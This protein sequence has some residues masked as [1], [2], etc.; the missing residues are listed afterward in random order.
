MGPIDF[1]K[2]RFQK[3]CNSVALVSKGIETTYDELLEVTNRFIEEL[4]D[5]GIINGSI[6]LLRGDYSVNSICAL[7]ALIELRC[8]IV[9]LTPI[10]FSALQSSIEE[11][12]AQF[13]V[14][15]DSIPIYKIEKFQPKISTPNLFK[16]LIDRELPGLVLFTS[17]SS[18]NPKAVVHDFSKLLEKF[19][20]QRAPMKTLN[21]LLFDH[22]GGLNTLFHCL[23]NLC[24]VIIPENRTPD[25]ICMLIEHY[26]IELLPTTP[27][28]LNILLI[29]KAYQRHDLSSLQLITYGAE[30]MSEVTLISLYKNFPKI[31]I[32]QT[33][34]MI[35]FGV[36]QSKS[37]SP[38]S[39]WVK[40][41]GKGCQIRVVDNKLEIK[42]PSLMLGYINSE[43][44]F[45]DD[46][47]LRT[48]DLVEQDGEWI[49]IL[50]RESDIIN[51]GGQKVYPTEVE[52]VILSC[53]GVNDVVVYGEKNSILGNIVCATIV[54]DDEY[55]EILFRY[56]L[57]KLCSNILQPYMVPIKIKFSK[58]ILLSNRFKR[59]RK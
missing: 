32:S 33:Y 55:D 50:G 22:W 7:L 10:S 30:P 11:V 44:P 4:M 28:F 23:S 24:P 54:I 21:F 45:T 59:I 40:L 41:G 29:S 46:G 26:R 18:G 34:G 13:L 1:L 49:R 31:N 19:H 56:N 36:L 39:L 3:N 58:E 48:G 47:F 17:G 53:P 38:D 42:S 25:S 16:S 12:G 57:R 5:A 51:V 8:I 14:D 52:Q 15:C 37:K 6:V 43:S 27:S 20:A 2:D 9:P 35:E